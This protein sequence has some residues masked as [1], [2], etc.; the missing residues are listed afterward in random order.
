[1]LIAQWAHCI[2]AAILVQLLPS[3]SPLAALAVY[4]E[5]NESDSEDDSDLPV[6]PSGQRRANTSGAG[7]KTGAGSA[8]GGGG[9]PFWAAPKGK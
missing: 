3:Q 2:A 8:G 5:D 6:L 4:A 7:P 9:L 1:V